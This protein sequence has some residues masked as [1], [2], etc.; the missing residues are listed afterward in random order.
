VSDAE[1]LDGT[2]A[3]A[4]T[5]GDAVREERLRRQMTTRAL[6]SAAG[7]SQPFLTNVENGRV[8]P[9]IASLYSIARALGVPASALLPE[10]PIRI[11]VVRADAGTRMLMSDDETAG[12]TQVLSGAKGRALMAYRFDLAP[13]FSEDSPYAH[14]GE[15]FVHVLTGSLIYQYEGHA[16]VELQAGDCLWID[17][18][19]HHTWS[20]PDEQDGTTQIMLVTASGVAR[21]HQNPAPR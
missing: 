1:P 20:V 5:V 4:N 6:A 21:T 9:S 12:Y 3:P 16:D 14:E 13:G 17:G 15:D 8:T 19:N 18:R 10:Q 11:E 2:D 7:V